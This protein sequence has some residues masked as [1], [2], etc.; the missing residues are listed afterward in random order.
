MFNH[1]HSFS[2]SNFYPFLY[3]NHRWNH[4]FLSMSNHFHSSSTTIVLSI[5][6]P[7]SIIFTYFHSFPITNFYPFQIHLQSFSYIFIAFY[8][9]P[10]ISIPFQP[11]KG[12]PKRGRRLL[13]LQVELLQLT[14]HGEPG[15]SGGRLVRAHPG[16]MV[17]LGVNRWD[18]MVSMDDIG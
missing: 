9:F 12:R 13:L 4:Q 10:S 16:W 6:D 2:I 17:N 15:L 8:Q 1:F 3:L 7:S 18:W 14:L 5:S 11:P